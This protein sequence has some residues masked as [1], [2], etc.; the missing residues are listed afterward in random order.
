MSPVLSPNSL[1]SV[2]TELVTPPL[3]DMILPGVTRD[4]IMS[5]AAAHID[6]TTDFR[7]A[8]LPDK[9]IVTERVMTMPEVVKASANGSLREMFGSGTAAIVSPVNMIGYVS[10]PLCL[11]LC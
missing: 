7:I 2:A 4:S 6:P 1:T 3:D 10:R 8:G 11:P 9:L 5:L